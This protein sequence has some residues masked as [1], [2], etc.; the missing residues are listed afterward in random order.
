MREAVK[1]AVLIFLHCHKV[2]LCRNHHGPSFNSYAFD[3]ARAHGFRPNPLTQFPTCPLPN[4]L[5]IMR[6]MMLLW[7]GTHYDGLNILTQR[8]LQ[9]LWL[10]PRWI[11]VGWQ[12][13][14]L[15]CTGFL[16]LEGP[17]S[18]SFFFV[19][20]AIREPRPTNSGAHTFPR[21]RGIGS[22]C[23]GPY[24]ILRVPPILILDNMVHMTTEPKTS[25]FGTS[26]VPQLFAR[27]TYMHPLGH[28]CGPTECL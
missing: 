20:H 26:A 23:D 4:D 19:L 7:G 25:I 14:F 1:S 21:K 18:I 5:L 11:H 27:R 17:K 8:S 13:T 2:F 10:K 12:N 16:C 9:P 28:I 6:T 15:L 22:T 3:R 24:T